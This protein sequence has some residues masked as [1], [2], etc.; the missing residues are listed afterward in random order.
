MNIAEFEALVAS[1]LDGMPP[2]FARAMDNVEV[3]VEIW[4]T[5]EELSAGNVEPGSTLLGLY[6]GV[7]KTKRGSY[8]GALPDK[9]IIFAGPILT[10]S[11]FDPAAV[12]REVRNTVLHE[13]GHHF[14]LNE[15]EIAKAL[16]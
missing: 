7:P 11:G 8:I 16:S 1:A 12:K 4:P 15:K 2:E 13:V 5:A 3:V 6:H 10:M 14:G 9:I